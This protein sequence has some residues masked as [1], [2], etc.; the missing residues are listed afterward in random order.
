MTWSTPKLCSFMRSCTSRFQICDRTNN[1]WVAIDNSRNTR[2][3]ARYFTAILWIV[4]GCQIWTREVKERIKQHNLRAD[5]VTIR[6]ELKYLIG[7]KGV[8]TV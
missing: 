5:H 3:I 1:R 4:V 7:A 6:S 8:G 2:Q